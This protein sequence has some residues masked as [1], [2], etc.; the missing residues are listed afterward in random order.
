MTRAY[1]DITVIESDVSAACKLLRA[2]LYFPDG[3]DQ[4]TALA[5]LETFAAVALVVMRKTNPSKIRDE[6]RTVEIKARMDGTP[7]VGG[8]A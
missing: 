3:S 2:R 7:M 8:E 1:S 6:A 4:D 5:T